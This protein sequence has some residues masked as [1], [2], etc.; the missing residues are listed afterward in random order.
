MAKSLIIL[1]KSVHTLVRKEVVD[2]MREVLS[3][4]DAGAELAP[5][6]I[7]RVKKSLQDKK[8]GRVTPLSKVF[9]Q[10]GI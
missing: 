9:K 8:A 10:Y 5:S 6:F 3:D 4:P 7:V 1:P 2:V